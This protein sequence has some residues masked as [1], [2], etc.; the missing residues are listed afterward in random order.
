MH[1]LITLITVSVLLA[2][3]GMAF[4]VYSLCVAAGRA[5]RYMQAMSRKEDK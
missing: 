4:L 1:P 2:V 3:A 5:D